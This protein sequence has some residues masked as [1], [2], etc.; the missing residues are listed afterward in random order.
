[1][2]DEVVKRLRVLYISWKEFVPF[3]FRQ[4]QFFFVFDAGGKSITLCY[5]KCQYGFSRSKTLWQICK[6]ICIDVLQWILNSSFHATK[7]YWWMIG[8]KA[9]QNVV[10]WILIACFEKT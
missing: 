10:Q 7:W 8:N 3:P 2:V 4:I 1:M 9:K 5:F 6:H